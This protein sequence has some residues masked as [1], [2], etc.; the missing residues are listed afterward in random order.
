MRRKQKGAL[1]LSV[2]LAS[3]LS[4]PSIAM[5]AETTAPETSQ[6]EISAEVDTAAAE[7]PA[8]PV[9]SE[10]PA[11]SASSEQPAASASSEQP[12]VPASSEQPAAPVSEPA[13]NQ[14]AVDHS[15]G[16]GDANDTESSAKTSSDVD[17]SNS[18]N[19]SDTSNSSEPAEKDTL[20]SEQSKEAGNN[21]GEDQKA[22][23]QEAQNGIEE[24][25]VDQKTTAPNNVN[26]EVS[27]DDKQ[28]SDISYK[29]N[30]TIWG[31][32]FPVAD[33]TATIKPEDANSEK[34]LGEVSKDFKGYR[35]WESQG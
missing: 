26:T 33:S 5:A 32:E 22:P 20:S 7:Q 35:V 23:Q 24:P 9:S 29:A 18:G 10:Q 14:Q 30:M 28:G 11:A 3:S 19:S 12:A 6:V 16:N 34:T 27:D 4:A 15:T 25:A 1:A 21:A 13:S 8:A 2:I 31:M 17:S